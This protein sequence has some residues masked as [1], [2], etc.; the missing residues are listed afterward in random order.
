MLQRIVQWIKTNPKTALVVALVLVIMWNMGS[1]WKKSEEKYSKKTE[2]NKTLQAKYE[3]LY[4]QFDEYKKN[5][6]SNMD[7][8]K[9]PLVIG[10][11]VALDGNGKVVYEIRYSKHTSSSEST[12]HAVTVYSSQAVTVVQTKI[13]YVEKIKIVEKGKLPRICA[14]LGGNL[15][16]M[17]ASFLK[18]GQIFAGADLRA[19]GSFGAG[20]HV[21]NS[22]PIFKKTDTSV[23]I[24]LNYWR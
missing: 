5:S 16:A 24:N 1:G 21:T 8:S 13:E 6:E 12:Q 10:D 4:G 11:K 7:V 20:L 22:F 2:E 14:Q 23:F 3:K 15:D 19:F 17:N 9:V 18:T